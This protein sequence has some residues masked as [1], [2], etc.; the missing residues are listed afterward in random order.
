M[1]IAVPDLN[2]YIGHYKGEPSE[3]EFRQYAIKL[4]LYLIRLKI[5]V[6]YQPGT[7]PY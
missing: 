3:T 4:W 5:G 7:K 1:R 6:I 2:K